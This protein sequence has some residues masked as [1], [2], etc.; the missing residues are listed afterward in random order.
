MREGER[1]GA[2]AERCSI[3]ARDDKMQRRRASLGIRSAFHIGNSHH[4]STGRCASLR[5]SWPPRTTRVGPPPAVR[6]R[7]PS[8]GVMSIISDLDGAHRGHHKSL[9]QTQR[10]CTDTRLTFN[11]A[12]CAANW[13]LACSRDWAK[14]QLR[15]LPSRL[16]QACLAPRLTSAMMTAASILESLPPRGLQEACL[17]DLIL[18]DVFASTDF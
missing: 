6:A 15:Q 8:H 1:Q 11:T 5:S 2:A 17:L 13:S 10:A 4:R 12:S 14:C 18:H 3:P 16:G 9:A 7:L